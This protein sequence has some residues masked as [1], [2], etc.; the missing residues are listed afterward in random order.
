MKRYRSS[1]LSDAA[2][3]LLFV[4]CFIHIVFT[5]GDQ[6]RYLINM[7]LL[8]VSFLIAI[9]TYFTSIMVGLILNIVFIFG[10]GTYTLY[11]TF[12]VGESLQAYHYYW[13][14]MTPVFTI[15]VAL[16]TYANRE[17]QEEKE[18]LQKRNASLATIDE[19]TNLKNSRSFQSDANIFMALSTRYHIPLTLLVMTVKHWDELSRMIS[20]AQI[21]EMVYDISKLSETSIRMNDSL[22]MLNSDHPTWGLLLFTDQDGANV[23]VNRLKEKLESFNTIE[24]SNK[25]KHEMKLTIGTIQYNPEEIPTPLDFIK[26]ARQKME[27]DV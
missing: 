21:T 24:F 15:I 20:E 1:L 14:I 6:D 8:N 23:V 10:Y 13:L 5:A 9:L 17:L 3:L 18:Q 2:F 12:I 26:K 22:Y 7:I 25:Y 19:R 4:I 16:L 11:Q 27:Y